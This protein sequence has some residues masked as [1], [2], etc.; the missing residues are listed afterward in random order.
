[1]PV[2]GAGCS[3]SPSDLKNGPALPDRAVEETAFGPA[4]KA[5]N[6]RAA[7]PNPNNRAKPSS[8]RRLK[9]AERVVEF[10]FILVVLKAERGHR[11]LPSSL[12]APSKHYYLILVSRRHNK[13]RRLG[14]HFFLEKGIKRRVKGVKCWSAEMGPLRLCRLFDPKTGR[15]RS[16]G[17]QGYECASS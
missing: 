16:D 10:F 1:M 13:T 9:N 7:P 14:Q 6:A 11:L 5:N 17:T 3:G 4:P 15:V 8:M 2:K 12:V